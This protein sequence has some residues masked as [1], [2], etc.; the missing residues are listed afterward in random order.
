LKHH[1]EL[2]DTEFVKAFENCSLDPELFNHEAH[3]RIA[4]IHINKY[5]DEEAIQMV[6]KQLIAYVTHIGASD[7]FNKTLTVAAVKTVSH[8]KKKSES[9]TFSGF[10]GEFPRLKDN[11]RELMA[12][13]YKM[14]I[15]NSPSAKQTFLEPDLMPFEEED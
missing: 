10:I 1:S 15:Y 6:S 14:D 11:F 13:H 9:D 4:W 12:F 3:L 7:K 5:G 2:I 8:F